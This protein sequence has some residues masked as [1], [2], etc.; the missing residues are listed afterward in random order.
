MAQYLTI[1]HLIDQGCVTT[2]PNVTIR[3]GPNERWRG[4]K[5]A[6]LPFNYTL[7]PRDLYISGLKLARNYTFIVINIGLT[8]SME[9]GKRTYL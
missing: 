9:E 7:Y 8:S 1:K 4:S 5:P 6:S 2:R 3:I